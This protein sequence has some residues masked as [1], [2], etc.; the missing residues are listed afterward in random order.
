MTK[1][2]LALLAVLA[3]LAIPRVARATEPEI[4][5][6][7]ET[8]LRIVASLHYSD[9]NLDNRFKQCQVQ[10]QR[11]IAVLPVA[12][13]ERVE[14]GRIRV[15]DDRPSNDT[16]R[17]IVDLLAPGAS[18]QCTKVGP[19]ATLQAV[20]VTPMA[21]K[22]DPKG[23]QSSLAALSPGIDWF[24]FRGPF[25]D[26]MLGALGT[27]TTCEVVD[28]RDGKC[29]VG[30][31]DETDGR[32]RLDVADST[33]VRRIK[34]LFSKGPNQPV[35]VD[36]AR[37]TFH[38]SGTL[39]YVV[40]GATRQ[41]LF[42]TS[43]L[44]EC[45]ARLDRV[46]AM[47]LSGHG[48]ISVGSRAYSLLDQGKR[49][50]LSN[51][52]PT[53][54][55]G[56]LTFTLKANGDAIGTALIRVLDR[57]TA[58]DSPQVRI[59]YNVG[60]GNLPESF[61][62]RTNDGIA[63]V[64]PRNVLK[65]DSIE[66][67][68]SLQIRPPL[69]AVTSDEVAALARVEEWREDE[70]LG[71]PIASTS[72]WLWRIHPANGD[73]SLS[74]CPKNASGP[75][76]LPA[77]PGTIAFSLS[78]A[79]ANPSEAKLELVE[80]VKVT[81][82]VGAD[83]DATKLERIYRR[84]LLE[85]NVKLANSARVE[86]LPLPIRDRLYVD[87]RGANTNVA[88]SEMRAVDD[89]DVV[90]GTC[91]LVLLPIPIGKP[92][93]AR[94]LSL[95]RAGG[96]ELGKSK[97]DRCDQGK[98][99]ADEC[100]KANSKSPECV[101]AQEMRDSCENTAMTKSWRALIERWIKLHDPEGTIRRLNPFFGPQRLIVSVRR[102]GNEIATK[103]WDINPGQPT[104]LELP[105]G[106]DTQRGSL[107]TVEVRVAARPT[108]DVIYAAATADSGSVQEGDIPQ[109]ELRF[110]A[111]LRSRGQFGI[112]PA[113]RT[114]DAFVGLRIY[115]TIP[116]QLAGLRFPAATSELRA[117]SDPERS[118]FMTPRTG[119]LGVIEPWNYD[120]GQNPWPLNLAFSGGLLAIELTEPRVAISTLFGVQVKAPFLNND[121]GQLT[122]AI[123][124]GAFWEHGVEEKENRFLL[125]FG[126]NVL[127]LFAGN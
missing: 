51:V 55:T 11:A 22:K 36:V 16:D 18:V 91:A 118:Q 112:K 59:S 38:A 113:V 60:A 3:W 121:S 126:A 17:F 30:L 96:S 124:L 108:S 46:T 62:A 39:P 68:V 85:A 67:A 25:R 70:K 44:R 87:C 58:G 86:S 13:G 88:N 102:D 52:P 93:P 72:R 105:H 42:L 57:I 50:E 71:P 1:H 98:A 45:E 82:A 127:S 21:V 110:G 47:E 69:P 28:G 92:G 75:C 14:I 99:V 122:S 115:A 48:L 41:T 116:V 80:V 29:S 54:S 40:A 95:Y 114:N 10:G 107:Y 111:Q 81:T 125:T 106:T 90:N 8:D 61:S 109:A 120:T 9:K 19:A 53:L 64:T 84:S 2:F 49:I 31:I 26:A 23:M 74:A 6:V 101:S 33:N 56:E 76:D 7:L 32:L 37:C 123:A 35:L 83:K 78:E 5:L 65:G 27:P 34:L 94:D 20:T 79:S 63:V 89:D 97:F 66:N 117:S 15:G 4:Q 103:R 119:L 73:L 77:G 100:N 43:K 104:W 12:P 24:G